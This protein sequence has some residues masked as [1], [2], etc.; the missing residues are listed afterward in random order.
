MGVI[1][2]SI[3]HLIEQY[4]RRDKQDPKKYQYVEQV[5]KTV[6]GTPCCVQMSHTLNLNG[7]QVPPA[8]YRRNPI[9]KLKIDTLERFYLLATDEI[10]VFLWTMFGEPELIN[11][12]L[13]KRRSIAQIK[14]YI[15]K[16]PGLLVFRHAELRIPP[17]KDKF[18]HTELWDG[19]AMVQRDMSEKLFNCPR[20]LMWDTNDTPSWLSDHMSKQR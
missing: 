6:P 16:R 13:N 20:V 8:S 3:K 19:K 17:P 11:L 7:I 15:D 5:M 18:E 10:E 4:P 9:P 1:P 12:D 2:V 14:A